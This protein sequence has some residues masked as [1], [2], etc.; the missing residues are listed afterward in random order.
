V[1]PPRGPPVLTGPKLR[2]RSLVLA[3][4]VLLGFL[5]WGPT[6]CSDNLPDPNIE[7]CTLFA[8]PATLTGVGAAFPLTVEADAGTLTI[9][10]DT[11][12]TAPDS[13]HTAIVNI[14]SGTD[15]G[16]AVNAI[17]AE[18]ATA[19]VEAGAYATDG[20][21]I[22]IVDAINGGSSTLAI[23]DTPLANALGF[24]VHANNE[25][26]TGTSSTNPDGGP[27]IV[28]NVESQCGLHLVGDVNPAC[29]ALSSA[30]TFLTTGQYRA[31]A[32]E[33]QK[34]G[35]IVRCVSDN[36]A[37]CISEGPTNSVVTQCRSQYSDPTPDPTCATNCT[38]ARQTCEGS[39]PTAAGSSAQACLDC[40]FQCGSVE[41]ACVRACPS[42]D[43]G[44]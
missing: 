20:G 12:P 10:V 6:S 5:A 25:W 41:V 16:G 30:A 24:S 38:T 39:C 11:D 22:Q 1:P 14:G 19:R 43:G 27:S 23:V 4:G 34:V 18:F 9:Y 21:Q 42:A 3:S 32:C 29:L 2:Y 44:M 31:R 17:N 35:L 36:V 33:E 26:G 13:A 7:E 8:T 15:L 28:D 40:S 37:Q